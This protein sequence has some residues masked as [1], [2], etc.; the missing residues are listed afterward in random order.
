MASEEQKQFNLEVI[1]KQHHIIAAREWHCCRNCEHGQLNA[2]AIR[3]ALYACVPP[4]AVLI[5]GCENWQ[6]WAPF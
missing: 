6:E 4:A 5:V 2:E 1:E 3:C